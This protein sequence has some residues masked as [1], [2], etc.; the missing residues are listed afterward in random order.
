MSRILAAGAPAPT[1]GPRPARTVSVS[2]GP[3]RGL[4]APPRA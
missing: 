2:G 4:A 1:V 3:L